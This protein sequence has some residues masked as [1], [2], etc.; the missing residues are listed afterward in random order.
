MAKP[1]WTGPAPGQAQTTRVLA[2]R[3]CRARWSGSRQAM[4]ML[5][6]TSSIDSAYV[7]QM[8]TAGQ[9]R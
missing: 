1:P 8:V 4:V 7:D 5:T 3:S 9:R 6:A 2:T